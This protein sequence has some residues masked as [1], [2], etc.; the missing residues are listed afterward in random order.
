MTVYSLIPGEIHATNVGSGS[1]VRFSKPG[2][3]GCVQWLRIG[4]GGSDWK[5][6]Q[7]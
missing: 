6:G 3:G 5:L 4:S 1:L 7:L 2:M